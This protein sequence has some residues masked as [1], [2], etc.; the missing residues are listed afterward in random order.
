[1]RQLG[2]IEQSLTRTRTLQQALAQLGSL[3]APEQLVGEDP[4]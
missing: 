3:S 2:E 1:M 4:G